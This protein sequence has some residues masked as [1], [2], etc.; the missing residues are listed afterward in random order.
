MTR[1]KWPFRFIRVDLF[2][3]W[4]YSVDEQDYDSQH[5][6]LDRPNIYTSSIKLCIFTNEHSFLHP[7]L[8]SEWTIKFPKND[9]GEGGNWFFKKQAGELKRTKKEWEKICPVRFIS[10]LAIIVTGCPLVLLHFFFKVVV[11]L[12]ITYNLASFISG[13]YTFIYHGYPNQRYK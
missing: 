6:V 11:S 10:L 1:M 9:K 13:S 4:H 3:W 12:L 5:K 7:C 2:C 8:F